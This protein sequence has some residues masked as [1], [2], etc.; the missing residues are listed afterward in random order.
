VRRIRASILGF[1]LQTSNLS[2]NRNRLSTSDA[3]DTSVPCQFCNHSIL[4]KESLGEEARSL[5]GL[6]LGQTLQVEF[7]ELIKRIHAVC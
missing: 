7:F 2:R 1:V 5:R 6:L 4:T 3:G